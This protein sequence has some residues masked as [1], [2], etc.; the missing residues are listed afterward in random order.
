MPGQNLFARS[1]E[2][3][4]QGSGTWDTDRGDGQQAALVHPL[5]R[6]FSLSVCDGLVLLSTPTGFQ[7]AGRVCEGVFRKI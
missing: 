7:T 4:Q 6:L 3:G 1:S 2:A 5:P